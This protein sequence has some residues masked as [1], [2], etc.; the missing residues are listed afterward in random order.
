MIRHMLQWFP[1]PQDLGKYLD[2]IGQPENNFDPE[3]PI[4]NTWHVDQHE[5][6]LGADKDGLFDRAV[7]HLLRYR[8]YPPSVLHHTSDF[9][10]EDRILR[11][12]DRIVQQIHILPGLLD[13][14]TMNRITATLA[15]PNRIG[16][17]YTTTEH[18]LEMGEWTATVIRKRDGQVVIAMHAV[19]KSGPKMPWWARPFARALQLRAHRLGVD[20]FKNLLHESRITDY[21]PRDA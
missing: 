10:R 2:Q 3:Q 14:L 11:Y 19:S 13:V 16:F 21:V 6:P 17:T 7:Q 8:F 20:H 4:D 9:A 12:G 18:H 1:K 5:M 15:E